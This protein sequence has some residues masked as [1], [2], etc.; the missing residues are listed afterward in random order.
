VGAHQNNDG[1]S[2]NEGAAYIFFGASDLSGT[3]SLGG[4]DSADVTILGKATTDRL[5][6]S[7]GGGR[8][9]PGP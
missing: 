8:S 7:V 1:G 9:N 3:K 4:A 6:N 2:D 5:G